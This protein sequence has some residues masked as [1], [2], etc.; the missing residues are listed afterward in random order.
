MNIAQCIIICIVSVIY[1][2][3][4]SERIRYDQCC[5]SLYSL[6]VESELIFSH[7][8]IE[9]K[10]KNMKSVAGLVLM[11]SRENYTL[12]GVKITQFIR[13]IL[14]NTTPKIIYYLFS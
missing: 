3:I 8:V 11:K 9:E 14:I 1:F 12:N 5:Y 13:P 2:N 7:K 10:T 4:H 6:L